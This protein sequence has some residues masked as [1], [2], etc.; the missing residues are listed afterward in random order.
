MDC[1][2]LDLPHAQPPAVE[3]LIHPTQAIKCGDVA[4]F[5]DFD[6]GCIESYLIILNGCG[7]LRGGDI[8]NQSGK[9][10]VDRL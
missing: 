6:F 7:K 10:M 3:G 9:K 8:I 5:H 4:G 2:G 1:G